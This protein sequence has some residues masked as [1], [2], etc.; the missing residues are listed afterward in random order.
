MTT[1]GPRRTTH[2]RSRLRTV[3]ASPLGWPTIAGSMPDPVASAPAR[4][5]AS[6]APRIPLRVVPADLSVADQSPPPRPPDPPP[7]PGP[8]VGPGQS[9]FAPS[10]P[11]VE[12]YRGGES[13]TSRASRPEVTQTFRT[14]PDAIGTMLR[15]DRLTGLAGLP[16]VLVH[17]GAAVGA[18]RAVVT[19]AVAVV[20]V[21]VMEP[22]PNAPPLPDAVSERSWTVFGGMSGAATSWVGSA[23]GPSPSW[24][25]SGTEARTDRSSNG[26]W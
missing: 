21:D 8:P 19:G 12:W 23:T 25:T 22:G 9:G 6:R 10:F 14:A 17:I 5:A 13:E 20:L 3:Q 24:R 11:A 4:P 26:A 1:S 15:P 16:S 7:W 18:L 2:R